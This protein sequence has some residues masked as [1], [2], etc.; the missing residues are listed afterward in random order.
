[1]SHFT[2]DTLGK[3]TVQVIQSRKEKKQKITALTAYDYPSARLVDEAGIDIILVGDSLSNVVLGHENTLSVTLDEMLVFARAVR[4]GCK[5]ALVVG[6]MPFGSYHIS[7]EQALISAVRYIKE[8]GVEAVK[9]EG[10]RN[11]ALLVE[12]LVEN[13]IPVM[14][15]IGLTPQSVHKMGGYK[16]QG[17]TI[18]AAQSLIEDAVTLEHAGIFSLVL[19]G[20]PEEIAEMIT[21]RIS[22]PTIGIGAGLHCDGQILVYSDLLGLTFGHQAK[23]VRKYA[24]LKI[25]ISQALAEYVDD[26]HKENFPARKESYHMPEELL[27]KLRRS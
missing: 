21:E 27:T 25:T 2:G 7:E 9:I 24:D 15:H 13:E 20:I 5:R 22:I 1:M 3:I 4:R 23:F 8:G 12:R 10:G 19:E 17:K 6:D 16:V 18:N 26:I 11:R 14:G